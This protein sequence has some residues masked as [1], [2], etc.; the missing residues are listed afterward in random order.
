MK[1][2]IPDLSP[3]RLFCLKIFTPRVFPTGIFPAGIFSLLIGRLF[4]VGLLTALVF[5]FPSMSLAT[6]SA[7]EVP[8]YSDPEELASDLLQDVLDFN[9]NSVISNLEAYNF[10]RQLA[11]NYMDIENIA[12]SALGIYRRNITEAQKQKFIPL[13][14][15]LILLKIVKQAHPLLRGDLKFE[16]NR[17]IELK[18]GYYRIVYKYT[19]NYNPPKDIMWTVIRHRDLGYYK[20]YDYHLE[21][22]SFLTVERRSFVNIIQRSG[23]DGLF[24]NMQKKID[25]LRAKLF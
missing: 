20:V 18:P 5:V 16:H 25:K 22:L 4:S 17:T 1:N 2:V 7:V 13:F 12:L 8:Q 24:E 23:F 10:Y 19:K 3:L 9:Q 6:Q 11:Y 21:G 14:E 15:E